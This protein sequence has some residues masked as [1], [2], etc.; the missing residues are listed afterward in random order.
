MTRTGGFSL[1][2]VDE[3]GKAKHKGG[4]VAGAA[5]ALVCRGLGIIS[6]GQAVTAAALDE[7]SGLFKDRVET[8]LLHA[9]K[10]LFKVDTAADEAVD[11]ALIGHGGA[12]G[13]DVEAD[14]E[15]AAT[16]VV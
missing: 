7:F 5:E 2:R 6:E 13:L 12:Q 16:S 1:R 15:M 9:I 10:V 8:E 4:P 3:Q 14:A 11:E